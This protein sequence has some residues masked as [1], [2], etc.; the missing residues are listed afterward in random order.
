MPA[1]PRCDS[2]GITLSVLIPTRNR[3]DYLGVALASV[4]EQFDGEV[5][6]VVDGPADAETER[7]AH[8]HAA[9][10]HTLGR[11]EGINV[12]RNAAVAAATGDLLAFL[13]DDVTVWPGWRDALER[14]AAEHPD[15]GCFGGPI[16]P[17]LEGPH[18]PKGCGRLQDAPVTALDLGSADQETEFAWGANFAVRRSALETVGRFDPALNYSGDEEDWQR[19]LHAVGGTV[20]YVARAGVEHRRTGDDARLRALVRAAYHRGRAA[21][22]DDERKGTAPSLR[23]EVR[24]LAGTLA[25]VARHGCAAGL[26]P[27]ARTAGR[28]RQA[29]TSSSR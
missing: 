17:R 22:R 1:C 20:R 5:I 26:V 9:K 12:A 27:V 2:G 8:A 29:L 18:A 23:D 16:H 11:H 14:A 25:H 6:I 28:L 7:V 3:A 4:R 15:A 19:R 10:V 13:D 24:P 21:R